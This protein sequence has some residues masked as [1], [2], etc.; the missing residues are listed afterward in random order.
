MNDSRLIIEAIAQRRC[1]DATYNRTNM[2]L[3]P[4]VLYTRHGDLFVDAVAVERDGREPSEVKLGTFKLAGLHIEE[5]SARTFQPLP[6]F[7]ANDAR[8]RETTPFSVA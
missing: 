1:V 7:D 5:V 8:Y 4:H 6:D 3:A 2:K